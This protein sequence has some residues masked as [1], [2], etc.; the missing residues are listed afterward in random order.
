LYIVLMRAG[1]V[2]LTQGEEFKRLCS[3]LA[4]TVDLDRI[5]CADDRQWFFDLF[6]QYL[7]IIDTYY[8]AKLSEVRATKKERLTVIRTD[9]QQ[10][11]QS[12]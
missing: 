3:E 7:R 11:S 8:S 12:L 5:A 9:R 2:M 10:E 6:S 1:A 4:E